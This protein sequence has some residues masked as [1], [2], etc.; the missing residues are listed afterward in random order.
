MQG[1][2]SDE[3]QASR[4]SRSASRSRPEVLRRSPRVTAEIIH[5]FDRQGTQSG[6][7]KAPKASGSAALTPDRRQEDGQF[8][9]HGTTS[10]DS[11]SMF[12]SDTDRSYQ[13]FR[14]GSIH[15]LR[16]LL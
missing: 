14:N 13:F 5:V 12:Q 3:H 8:P 10:H 16:N 9:A 11:K 15:D 4:D 2:F 6:S 7:G 1:I